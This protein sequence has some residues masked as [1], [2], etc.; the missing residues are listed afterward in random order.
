MAYSFVVYGSVQSF[1]IVVIIIIII[2]IIITQSD[3]AGPRRSKLPSDI[4][5]NFRSFVEFVLQRDPAL[6]SANH[7]YSYLSLLLLLLLLLFL[8]FLL[9]LLSSSSSSSL[10]LCDKSI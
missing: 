1:H 5:S 10:S 9:F 4:D 7:C 8:L 3:L 2:I 6:R